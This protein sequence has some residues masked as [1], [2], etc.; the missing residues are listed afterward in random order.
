M[1][2]SVV[3]YVRVSTEGQAESG[4]GLEDQINKIKTYCSLYDLHLIEVVV[5]AGASAKSLEREGIQ[6]IISGAKAGA[7]GGVVVAKLDRLTRSMRDLHKLLDE[8]FGA[9]ELHSVAEKVDTSSAAGRLVLN[10]LMSV[11]EWER[12]T[13]GERTSA[14]LKVKQ[15]RGEKLGAAP[16]GQRWE[17]GRLVDDERE[18]EIISVVRELRSRGLTLRAIKDELAARRMSGRRGVSF[19]LST[20]AKVSVGVEVAR[21]IVDE[22]PKMT[23]VASRGKAP[24]GQRWEDGRLVSDGREQEII[25]VVR[26][27]RSRGWTLQ[28]IKD[29]LAVR[30]MSGRTGASFGFSTLAKIGAAA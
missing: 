16:F 12:E 14:A 21:A 13:I 9:V 10:V 23:P 30:R 15:A 7:F 26:D 27:L 11:A 24:F 4:L 18:Q 5:D 6:R 28:A 2:K 20:L 3:G 22:Q 29:E 1:I 17:E 25:S 8:V 19:S